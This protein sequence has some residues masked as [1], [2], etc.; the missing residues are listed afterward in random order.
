MMVEALGAVAVAY[1]LGGI[2]FGYLIGRS[3]GLDIR[4]HGSGNIGA[5]NVVRVLGKKLGYSCFLL[6]FGKGLAPVLVAAK[7]FSDSSQSGWPP[8]LVALA[9]VCGHVFSPYLKLRGGKG[10]ATATGALLGV[11]PIPLLCAVACWVGLYLLTRTVAV[12][13]IAAAVSL[14]IFALLGNATQFSRTAPTAMSLLVLIAAMIV[15][16]HRSNIQRMLAGA[17]HSFSER[18]PK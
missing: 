9:T 8:A 2:P 17:E 1:F 18:D 7:V 14:P 3:Q 15:I 12:A 5:T 4:E 11:A 10:V 16:R 6:D 13:S